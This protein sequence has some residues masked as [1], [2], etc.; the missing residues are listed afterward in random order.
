MQGIL[1]KMSSF[2]PY[3]PWNARLQYCSVLCK[4]ASAWEH[5]G[6]TKVQQELLL[7]PVTMW[8]L[9][10]VTKG[11]CQRTW[12]GS[13]KV[14]STLPLT[15][16]ALWPSGAQ[17]TVLHE[18]TLSD[19]GLKSSSLC[20][21]HQ[22]NSKGWSKSS[23]GQLYFV[24]FQQKVPPSLDMY[25]MWHLQPPEVKS[26]MEPMDL[27]TCHAE[28][29]SFPSPAAMECATNYQLYQSTT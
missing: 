19:E 28:H 25:S 15:R 14:Q 11:G 21:V 24:P 18:V 5:T 3:K 8:M 12:K 17:C 6:D 10:S 7:M 23:L 9:C 1:R 16:G 26:P 2:T 22:G 20:L 29:F 27:L 4:R 13:G